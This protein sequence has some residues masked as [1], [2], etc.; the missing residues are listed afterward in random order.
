MP[1]RKTYFRCSVLTG[2]CFSVYFQFLVFPRDSGKCSD[3][4]RLQPPVS[5]L[6][7]VD[8]KSFLQL[9]EKK[10][11]ASPDVPENRLTGEVFQ[12]GQSVPFPTKLYQ[13]SLAF[14]H[15]L[16]VFSSR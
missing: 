16:A 10:F 15:F 8:G 11:L 14:Y 13:G 4:T 1:L 3:V 7:T 2:W 9:E 12:H 6:L 5:S